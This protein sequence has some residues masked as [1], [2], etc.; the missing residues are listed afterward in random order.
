MHTTSFQNSRFRR[1]PDS[2]QYGEATVERLY[3]DAHC[4]LSA[5]AETD[6]KICRR[7]ATQE[8]PVPLVCL[9]YDN[10]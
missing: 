10:G 8:T 9:G 4:S 7:V 1:T 3:G 2:Q 5:G 6:R